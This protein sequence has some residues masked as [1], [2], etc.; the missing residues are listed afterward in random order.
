LEKQKLNQKAIRMIVKNSDNNT[1]S[2]KKQY[3]WAWNNDIDLPIGEYDY[4]NST[5]ESSSRISDMPIE[6][7]DDLVAIYKFRVSKNVIC[8]MP[9]PPVYSGPIICKE[10][11]SIFDSLLI[12]KK[13]QYIKCTIK[14]SDGYI[15]NKFYMPIFF[16]RSDFI[17]IDRSVINASHSKKGFVS[18]LS[19]SKVNFKLNHFSNSHVSRDMRM[20]TIVYISDYVRSKFMESRGDKRNFQCLSFGILGI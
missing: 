11:K 4:K 10:W 20:K 17:D 5:I 13:I 9:C 18:I 12:P 6:Q 19:A 1:H 2:S 8:K 14:C 16:D 15:E 7:S 3:I